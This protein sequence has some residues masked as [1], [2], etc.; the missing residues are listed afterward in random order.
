MNHSPKAVLFD[1]DGTLL[2]TAPDLVYALNRLRKEQGFV[3]L[4]LADLRPII[5]LGA[6]GMLKQAIDIEH[7]HEDFPLLRERFLTLYAEHIADQT[8]FFP[9]MEIVL[10]H[11]ETQGIPWGIVTNKYTKHTTSLLNA[12]GLIKR[13]GCVVCGDTLA[14][15]KPDPSPI[16]HAC[17]LLNHNPSDCLYVGDSATDV[18]ASLRAGAR[19][20]VAL[21]GYLS[22]EDQPFTWQAQGYINDPIEI[23]EWIR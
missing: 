8:T 2:D 20:L 7:T 16:L 21:Y 11:L 14:Q 6:R 18:I 17:A 19:S 15:A 22:K 3:E 10:S 5:S 13:P 12:L 9:N 1:L 4:P 23:L